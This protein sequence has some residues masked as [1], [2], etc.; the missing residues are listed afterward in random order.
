MKGSNFFSLLVGAAIGA[1][2]TALFTTDKGDEI[3]SSVKEKADEGIDA[4][5]KKIKK[6]KEEAEVVDEEPAAEEA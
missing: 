1:L 5:E 3:L 2:A 4:L 6:V